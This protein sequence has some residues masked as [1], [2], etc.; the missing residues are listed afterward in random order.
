MRISCFLLV[1]NLYLVFPKYIKKLSD[2]STFFCYKT[3]GKILIYIKYIDNIFFFFKNLKK[4]LI[5][6]LKLIKFKNLYISQ[7][8]FQLWQIFLDVELFIL[9]GPQKVR[10]QMRIFRKPMNK[11]FYI[12]QLCPHLLSVKKTFIKAE[13]TQFIIIYL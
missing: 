13:L 12:F 2:F 3:I 8:Y 10:I 6:T 1:A 4:A 5:F 7:D 11:F 9:S